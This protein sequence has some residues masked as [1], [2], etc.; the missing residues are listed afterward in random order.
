MSTI[1]DMFF[2]RYEGKSS[3][4]QAEL[5]HRDIGNHKAVLA[6]CCALK[7][8]LQRLSYIPDRAIRSIM[9]I[10]KLF[11]GMDAL[12]GFLSATGQFDDKLSGTACAQALSDECYFILNFLGGES[13]NYANNILL[14]EKELSFIDE[15]NKIDRE[16]SGELFNQDDKLIGKTTILTQMKFLQRLKRINDPCIRITSFLERILFMIEA[17][18]SY[19]EVTGDANFI[20]PNLK[21]S[22]TEVSELFQREIDIL[23]EYIST[24]HTSPDHHCGQ[25]IMAAGQKNW[26]EHSNMM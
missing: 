18:T 20:L 3:K 8:S 22:I 10:D 7:H 17:L 23:I 12:I 9:F 6:T 15:L 5:I 16:I 14:N 19:A 13:L 26:D 25:K 21:E 11:Q 4:E 2:Q 1:R 24:P